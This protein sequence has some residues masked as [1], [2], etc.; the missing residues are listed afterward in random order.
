MRLKFQNEADISKWGFPQF[1]TFRL[2]L[3]LNG[4]LSFTGAHPVVRE[5]LE[6]VSRG[7]FQMLNV[8]LCRGRI[9]DSLPTDKPTEITLR[10]N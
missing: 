1:L 10:S 8:G 6:L 4:G 5:N 7:R 9:Q 3:Y 2:C